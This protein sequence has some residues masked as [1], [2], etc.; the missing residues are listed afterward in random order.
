MTDNIDDQKNSAQRTYEI[1]SDATE[2]MEVGARFLKKSSLFFLAGIILA[3]SPMVL[4]SLGEAT[5]SSIIH[6]FIFVSSWIGVVVLIGS[7]VLA[8]IGMHKYLASR[9]KLHL[10]YKTL[11]KEEANESS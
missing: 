5:T 10:L 3:T 9:N 6:K 8:I 4:Q 7:S 1:Y 2:K 11:K